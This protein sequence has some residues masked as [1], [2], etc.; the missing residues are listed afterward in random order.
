[1]KAFLVSACCLLPAA[2]CVAQETDCSAPQATLSFVERGHSRTVNRVGSPLASL[3]H[4]LAQRA[5]ARAQ[6]RA[7]A[8]EAAA[9]RLRSTH[10]TVGTPV[11]GE[12]DCSVGVENFPALPPEPKAGR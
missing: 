10:S 11:A 7:A 6:V 5:L 1:M 4:R 9:T 3:R 12:A 2:F 8:A